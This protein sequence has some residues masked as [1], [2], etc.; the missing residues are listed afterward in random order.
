M[1]EFLLV[2]GRRM[3]PPPLTCTLPSSRSSF[4]SFSC[5]G[6]SGPWANL[7]PQHGAGSPPA[8]RDLFTHPVLL[9]EQEANFPV[10]RKT[11]LG[12]FVAAAGVSITP[13]AEVRKDGL[14][15]LLLKI[16]IQ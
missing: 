14:T 6:G 15:F 9:L 11:V 1:T 12:L 3:H 4:D 8:L 7:S 10:N 16:K 13:E 2:Q 5:K